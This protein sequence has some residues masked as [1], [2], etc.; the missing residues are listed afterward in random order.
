MDREVR[1]GS[2]H[3][4]RTRCQT[5]K[6]LSVYEARDV[7]VHAIDA[8]ELTCRERCVATHALQSCSLTY[9]RP[10][11]QEVSQSVRPGHASSHVEHEVLPRMQ[12][13]QCRQTHGLPPT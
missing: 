4:I 6:N 13:E 9:A 5:S 2:M 3:V 10:G 7:A 11:W 1:G 8:C 12:P